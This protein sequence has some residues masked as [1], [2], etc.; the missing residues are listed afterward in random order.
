MMPWGIMWSLP[1][2]LWWD[3]SNPQATILGIFLFKEHYCQ[4]I[5]TL[6]HKQC[7]FSTLNDGFDHAILRFYFIQIRIPVCL[8]NKFRNIGMEEKNYS[9]G[10]WWTCC[11]SVW[12]VSQLGAKWV[13]LSNVMLESDTWTPNWN[14]HTFSGP[15]VYFCS[16]LCTRIEQKH[17][18]K[19]SIPECFRLLC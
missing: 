1:Q 4:N 5:I 10:K 6:Y 13:Y 8:S 7:K 2:W 18:N 3:N 19:I 16:Q 11:I 12:M 9:G 17:Y 14:V 15:K